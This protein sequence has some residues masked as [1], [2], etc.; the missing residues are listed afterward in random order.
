MWMQSDGPPLPASGTAR[1]T[2][3]MALPEESKIQHLWWRGWKIEE[4]SNLII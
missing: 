2:T 3:R 4:A 1:R